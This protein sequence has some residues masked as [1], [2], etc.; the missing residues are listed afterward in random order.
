MQ[1]A[2]KAKI[3]TWYGIMGKE[4]SSLSDVDDAE[5]VTLSAREV[6]L[7]SAD[8]A[9]SKEMSAALKENFGIDVQLRVLYGDTDSAFIAGLESVTDFTLMTKIAEFVGKFITKSYDKFCK[10]HYN[11]DVHYLKIRCEEIARVFCMSPKKGDPEKGGKKRYWYWQWGEFKGDKGWIENTEREIEIVG[12][13]AKRSNV[14]EIGRKVQK[15]VMELITFDKPPSF[16]K[17]YLDVVHERLVTGK[18]NMD[19]ITFNTTLYDFNTY[20]AVKKNKPKSAWPEHVRAAYWGIHKLKQSWKPGDK[21]KVIYVKDSPKKMEKM[22]V[23]TMEGG[24]MPKGFTPDYEEIYKKQVVDRLTSV[25]ATEGW[26]IASIMNGIT[27]T[28][29]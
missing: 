5:S 15:R 11:A 13:E 10:E 20:D 24:K 19:E 17:A 2:E 23:I 18:Y 29:L 4:G 14:A 22:D 1:K 8:V 21:V 28:S 26:T 7:H 27:A 12:F 25:V 6:I 3:N 9:S 16:I